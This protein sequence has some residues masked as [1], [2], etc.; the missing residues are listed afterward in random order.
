MNAVRKTA[1]QITQ[2]IDCYIR[3]NGGGYSQWYAGIAT[4]PR[5]RLFNDHNVDEKSGA[6]IYRD[7]GSENTA[8][9]IEKYFLNL[10]CE[11]GAGGGISPKFVYAY[12][13]TLNTRE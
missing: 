13:T 7:C 12:K 4:D 11:G 6:W 9:Q 10:S 1:T 3:Q 8:R 5:D 2:E